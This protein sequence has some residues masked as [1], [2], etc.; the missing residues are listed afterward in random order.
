MLI[1]KKLLIETIQVQFDGEER[2]NSHNKPM[3]ALHI[4]YP[5]RVV[6]QHSQ[7]FQKIQRINARLENTE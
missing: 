6:E 4:L 1:N 3:Y 5:T 2:S 7:T